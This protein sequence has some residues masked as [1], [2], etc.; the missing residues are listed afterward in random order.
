MAISYNARNFR[1][2]G[3]IRISKTA[4]LSHGASHG[5]V[6]AG[7]GPK[8]ISTSNVI[9]SWSTSPGVGHKLFLSPSVNN[10]RTR[11]IT[12]KDRKPIGGWSQV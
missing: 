1:S 3:H 12:G 10:I 5:A 6:G 8:N 4:Q 11:M 7:V 2:L 9:Q